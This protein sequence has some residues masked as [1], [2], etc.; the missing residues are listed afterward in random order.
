MS[1]YVCMYVYVFLLDSHNFRPVFALGL[2]GE[3]KIER[4]VVRGLISKLQLHV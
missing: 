1:F 4:R 2:T 3:R